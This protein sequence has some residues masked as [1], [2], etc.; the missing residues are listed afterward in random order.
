[1]YFMLTCQKRIM[2]RLLAEKPRCVA[3]NGLQNEFG[4][5]RAWVTYNV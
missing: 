5:K 1:M 4:L 3:Q 2:M